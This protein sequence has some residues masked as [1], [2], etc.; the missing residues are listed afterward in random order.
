MG[1]SI[2]ARLEQLARIGASE[3]GIDRPLA[4]VPERRARELFASWARRGGYELRQDRVGN[5]FAR[6]AG[7]RADASPVLTGSHL[8]TVAGGGAYDGALGVAAAICALDLLSQR[9]VET[10]HPLEAVAW[11]G[12]EGSR[13]PL[14]ALG[15]SVFCGLCSETEALGLCDDAGIALAAALASQDAG[16][17]PG[18]ERHAGSRPAAYVELHVEQGPVLEAAGVH[19]GVVTA[20]A[21]QRRYRITVEGEGG[22]AGTVPMAL[23]CDALCAAAELIL[24]AEDAARASGAGVATAGRITVEPNVP[25][26]IPARA[27]F[28]LDLRSPHESVIAGIESALRSRSA[29][30]EDAR[31]VRVRI[32]VLESRAP[33]AMD[34]RVRAAIHRAIEALD[35]R[36][37]DLPSGAGHD[38]MCL[39]H[40]APAG[41]IFVPSIGGRSHV[42]E[43]RT[44]DADLELGVEALAAALVEVDMRIG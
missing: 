29:A 15:S 34:D 38:A 25:N 14:G 43:E 6:R 35:S 8:D 41:M 42:K 32:D 24:H 13:F 36:A 44:T 1:D 23:R 5:L 33:A 30:V 17:L 12:E 19:L 39:A 9:G 40:V 7:K 3:N 16:L 10:A 20:I 11:A 22:H 21:G 18:L 2:V 26:V 31:G 28:S 4:S 37:L 27:T